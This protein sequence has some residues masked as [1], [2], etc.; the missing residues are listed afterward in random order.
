MSI[1]NCP[2]S[3]IPAEI[4]AGGPSLVIQVI[5]LSVFSSFADPDP[6]VFVPPGSGSVIICTDPDLG[7]DPSINKQSNYGEKISTFL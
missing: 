3:Q 6:L 4:V 5:S 2:L 1:E 7:S